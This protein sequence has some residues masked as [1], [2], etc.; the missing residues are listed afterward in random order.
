VALNCLSEEHMQKFMAEGW[1]DIAASGH[2]LESTVS[3]IYVNWFEHQ[4]THLNRKL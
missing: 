3:E 2:I 4:I 1:D